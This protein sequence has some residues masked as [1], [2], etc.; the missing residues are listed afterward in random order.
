MP[1]YV[2]QLAHM[3]CG[4]PACTQ[5]HTEPLVLNPRCHPGKPLRGRVAWS[6]SVLLLDCSICGRPVCKVAVT[7]S[8]TARRFEGTVTFVPERGILHVTA[9][10]VGELVYLVDSDPDVVE[11]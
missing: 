10:R 1:L 5:A 6:R 4:D 8:W 11:A 2:E 7:G 3:R 9:E